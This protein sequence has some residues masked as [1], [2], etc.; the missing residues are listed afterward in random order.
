MPTTAAMPTATAAAPAEFAPIGMNDQLFV[1]RG[2]GMLCPSF[3]TENLELHMGACKDEFDLKAS[4]SQ[5]LFYDEQSKEFD[6][7]LYGDELIEGLEGR[8]A[9]LGIHAEGKRLLQ[10]PATSCSS[11]ST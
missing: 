2:S 11:S 5:R 6:W 4:L 1:Q 9:Q 10:V 3:R 7:E 8:Q